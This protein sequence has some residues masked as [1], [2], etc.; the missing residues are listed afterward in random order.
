MT[1]TPNAMNIA[2][3]QIRIYHELSSITEHVSWYVIYYAE[4]DV[5]MVLISTF[6]SLC[7]A[8]C[9]RHILHAESSQQCDY[10]FLISSVVANVS[11]ISHCDSITLI[12]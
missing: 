6:L 4:T 5:L 10:S 2:L 3:K 9:N 1:I 12:T 11:V 8:C 7:C